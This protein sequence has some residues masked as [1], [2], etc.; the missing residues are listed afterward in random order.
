M[1]DE[2]CPWDGAAMARDTRPVTFSYKG[3][4][5]TL[6]VSGWYCEKCGEGIHT[7][8]ELA[9]VDKFLKRLK[10]DAAR[11]LAGGGGAP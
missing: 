10:A 6:D 8:A 1:A 4:S 9:A 11:P 2:V 3:F 7:G 5:E